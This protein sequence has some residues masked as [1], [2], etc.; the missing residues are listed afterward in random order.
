[1]AGI[2]FGKLR[3]VTKMS[4][5]TADIHVLLIRLSALGDVVHTIPAAALLRKKLPNAKLTWIVEAPF[6]E[7]LQNNP[8]VD[9]VLVFPKKVIAKELKNPL[10]LIS[11][12][13]EFRQFVDDLKSRKFTAAID[14]QGLFKS[15][16]IALLSG[17]PVRVGFSGARELS[18]LMMTHKLAGADYFSN[19]THVVDHNLDLA[20]FYL[21]IAGD[22]S[23]QSAEVN[24]SLPEPDQR[25][26]SR[27]AVLL[28]GETP[29][30]PSSEGRDSVSSTSAGVFGTEEVLP[31]VEPGDS[32]ELRS[33]T[34]NV[35]PPTPSDATGSVELR[36]T[37]AD[38]GSVK[39]REAPDAAGSVNRN[40]H[41]GGADRVK[42]RASRVISQPPVAPQLS[43]LIRE[44]KVAGKILI[45][46]IPGTTWVTKIWPQEKWSQLVS[47][48][49][50][51]PDVR[52]VLIG[53]PSEVEM[54]SYI[55]DSVSNPNV[56]NLTGKTSLTELIALF[57]VSDIV[58]GADTGP[59]HMAAATGIPRV[60]GVFGSTPWKRNGPAG[61]DTSA[62]ALSLSCQPC[63]E[64]T[65]P[66]G[67]LAC[68]KDLS[69]ASVYDEIKRTL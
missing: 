14:F 50:R 54:N 5:R 4:A 31:P 6:V 15:G 55:Y 62:V 23:A 53:G 66:L 37:P 17:A 60:V 9:E 38:T 30:K 21:R 2:T 16:V 35:K 3:I 19:D 39:P 10:N 47:Q 63:F 1:M 41:N 46:L 57:M 32:K 13:T 42:L 44:T 43:E 27:V 20:E 25:V 28:S 40:S 69:V 29:G 65:C 36:M 68:L 64:K 7:L 61:L 24:F 67:T 8:A 52:I 34:T 11:P 48:L 26:F 49:V 12:G 18:P 51:V 58:V 22:T 59:L 33:A 45:A 56:L